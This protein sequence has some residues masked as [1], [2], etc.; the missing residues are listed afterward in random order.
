MYVAHLGNE[1]CIELRGKSHLC[2]KSIINY[3]YDLDILRNIVVF[4]PQI[5][6]IEV[7]DI[8]NPLFNKKFGWSP[9]TWFNRGSTVLQL[10]FSG[11]TFLI[12]IRI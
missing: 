6:Y 3:M 2:Y 5:H 8:T 7:F 9:A 4:S 10:S 12:Y 11:L 1:N